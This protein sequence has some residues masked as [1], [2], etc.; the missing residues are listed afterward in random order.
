M[1]KEEIKKAQAAEAAAAASVPAVITT[2][3]DDQAAEM[4]LAAGRFEKFDITADLQSESAAY[5][6]MQAVDNRARVTLYNACNQPDKIANHINEIIKVLHIYA[7][8]IPVTN[9]VTGAI[10]KAPRVVLIDE[11][12]KGYQAV[13]I[14]IYNA[15]K[16][17]MHMFGDPSTWDAPHTVKVVNVPLE[18]GQHTFSLKMVD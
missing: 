10:D 1:S 4:M 14:G 12:G 7:E 6:S 15:V 2:D 9:K 16:Q 11:Q 8:I 18:G 17:L 5:C 3:D 13:S